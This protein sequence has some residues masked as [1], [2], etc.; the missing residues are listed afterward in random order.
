MNIHT[1]SAI[2]QP[3]RTSDDDESLARELEATGNFKILRRLVP[4]ISTA[5]PAG[6]SGKLGIILDVETTGLDP[7][8]DEIIEVAMVKFRYSET[9][10]I[11]GVGGVFQSYN[12]PSIP[13]PGLVTDLTGITHEMVA[14]HRIDCAVLEAFVADANIVIAHNAAF[15]RKFAERLLPIFEHKHWACTQTEIDWRRHGFGGAKLGYLLAEIGHFHNAHRAIDDC[16]ALVEILAYPLQAT[17]QSVF[18]EL[19]DCAR[20]STVRIWAQGSPFELKDALKAR[21]YRWNDGS[22]G[23]PKSWFIDVA[24]VARDAELNFL[25]K[26]IYQREVNIECRVMT[27]RERFSNRA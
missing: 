13:I 7:A 24:Q 16:H 17:S 27:A 11:T 18:A 1:Q 4:R 14:G 22:D 21:G 23:R 26:E 5:T 6:Y 2:T 3:H 25:S 8:K 19:I 10:E 15:D 20:R 12:E 9:D